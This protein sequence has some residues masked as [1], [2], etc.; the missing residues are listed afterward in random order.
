MSINSNT[1]VACPGVQS[2]GTIITGIMLS[3]HLF[4]FVGGRGLAFLIQQQVST[5]IAEFL[6]HQYNYRSIYTTDRVNSENEQ[7]KAL[8]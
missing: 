3:P 1:A 4:V 2:F 6:N 8:S 7:T 5:L